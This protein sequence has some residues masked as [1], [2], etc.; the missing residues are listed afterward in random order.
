MNWKIYKQCIICEKELSKCE[1]VRLN[2]IVGEDYTFPK[3]EEHNK[4]GRSCICTACNYAKG[5]NKRGK[6]VREK[7]LKLINNKKNVTNN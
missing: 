7:L 2:D 5:Y 3:Y 6:Q 4:D 1:C